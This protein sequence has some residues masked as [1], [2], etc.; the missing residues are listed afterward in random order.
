MADRQPSP[1][2]GWQCP[3]CP[4]QVVTII[5]SSERL[6]DQ[7]QAQAILEHGREHAD[8]EWANAVAASAART[9][10]LGGGVAG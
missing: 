5:G 4:H 8:R 6:A 2:L 1:A 10:Q 3:S 9:E 7:A